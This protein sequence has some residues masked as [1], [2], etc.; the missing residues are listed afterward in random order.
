[1]AVT[2]QMAVATRLPVH[3]R[4]NHLNGHSFVTPSVCLYSTTEL[5]GKRS[6]T[7]HGPE[8]IRGFTLL[9][10]SLAETVY[11]RSFTTLGFRR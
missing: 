11:R 1:M 10:P 6:L 4:T 9:S 7:V 2:Q 8:N 5:P 3:L